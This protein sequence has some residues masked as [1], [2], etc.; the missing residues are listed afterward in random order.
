[1]CAGVRMCGHKKLGGLRLA[2]MSPPLKI[3]S[4][5]HL[6]L[7]KAALLDALKISRCETVCRVCVR[8]VVCACV[9][10]AV[11]HV[12]VFGR[13]FEETRPVVSVSSN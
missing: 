6:I 3:R 7:I 1:M 5:G 9:C 10:V 2:L 11:M 13:S 4:P 8:E 12:W